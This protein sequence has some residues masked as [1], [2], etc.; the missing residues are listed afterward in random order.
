MKK[1]V[2]FL[3]CQISCYSISAQPFNHTTIKIKTK[4]YSGKK[5]FLQGGIY[6]NNN[7]FNDFSFIDS[8]SVEKV[9]AKI[10]ENA[11]DQF[12]INV[13]LNYTH[14]FQFSYFLQV[15]YLALGRI[16]SLS[17]SK[18]LKLKLKIYQL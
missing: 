17:G 14:P 5:I 2:F 13:K 8:N 12:D 18:M 3:L 15:V 9:S 16:F 10:I 4:F 1:F 11:S 7:E 6:S